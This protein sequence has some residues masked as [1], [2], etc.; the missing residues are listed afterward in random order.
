M[1]NF[2]KGLATGL[3]VAF[4]LQ[5]I[6]FALN[7]AEFLFN[8]LR[9]N[10]NGVDCVQWGEEIKLDNGNVVPYSILYKGTT[11][12]PLR[13]IG[14][15]NNKKVCWN[16]DTNTA[17]L[18][19][20]PSQENILTEKADKNGN[21]WTYYTFSTRENEKYLGV[22]ETKRGFERVYRLVGDSV[23]VTDERIYFMKRTELNPVPEIQNAEIFVIDFKNDVN[24][25]DGKCLKS[26]QHAGNV[27][28]VVFD[29]EYAFYVTRIPGNG[30]HSSLTAFNCITGE[31]HSYHFGTWTHINSPELL[32]TGTSEVSISFNFVAATA[33]GYGE[34]T[35]DKATG[36][37]SEPI[38]TREK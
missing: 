32:K 15:F 28:D 19:D 18:V 34:I 22:K 24:S 23:W 9:I 6:P 3:V 10:I 30:N 11:Y 8:K 2:F 7:G 37:F 12:L 38:M 31:E 35:F 13:K 5:S 14:E 20:A 1:K 4:C 17:A 16:G 33:S 21:L 26:V 36:E 25:Q 27:S 29:K